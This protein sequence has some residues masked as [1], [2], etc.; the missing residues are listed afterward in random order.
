[1]TENANSI[2]SA[3][4]IQGGRVPLDE[5]GLVLKPEGTGNGRPETWAL[6]CYRRGQRLSDG[7][8][9]IGPF[10]SKEAAVAFADHYWPTADPVIDA[11]VV[12]G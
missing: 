3:P 1:M 7:R 2:P 12:D 5:V 6:P 8:V 10:P 9:T 4:T 11:E